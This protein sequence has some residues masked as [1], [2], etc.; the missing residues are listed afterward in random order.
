MADSG[1]YKKVKIVVD[2]FALISV[3][4]LLIG[5]PIWAHYE[6]AS[7]GSDGELLLGTK[8]IL[9]DIFPAFFGILWLVFRYFV[10]AAQKYPFM[11]TRRFTLLFMIGSLSL[12]L[13]GYLILK[14]FFWS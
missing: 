3:G 1:N 10:P 13:T 8:L 12:Y 4:F 5:A 7:R 14:H 6:P 9:I 2:I 11:Q